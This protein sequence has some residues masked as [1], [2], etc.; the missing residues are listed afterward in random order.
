MSNVGAGNE[1]ISY[2]NLLS[3]PSASKEEFV[4]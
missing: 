4:H 3:A 1:I 2:C